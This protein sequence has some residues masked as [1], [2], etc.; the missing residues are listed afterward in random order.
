MTIRFRKEDGFT[1][2]DLIL[3]AADHIVSAQYLYRL[4]GARGVDSAGCL[5]HLGLELL[6]KAQLLYHHG[7]FT[8]EHSLTTLYSQLPTRVQRL[9]NHDR[10]LLAKWDKLF[11]LRYP[12]PRSPIPAASHDWSE[13][14]QLSQALI[15]LM[16]SA[17][18]QTARAFG[19]SQP[20]TKGGRRL[21]TLK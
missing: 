11:Q 18:H 1:E 19:R 10:E 3:Y 6:L 16:P 14:K 15:D 2:D 9:N 17:L 5:S 21:Y 7:Y 8:D 20:S 13:V 12:N 4:S